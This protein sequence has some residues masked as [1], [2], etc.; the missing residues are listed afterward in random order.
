MI[1]QATELNGTNASVTMPGNTHGRYYL[2]FTSTAIGQQESNIVVYS[3]ERE[4][5]VVA[6]SASD[7]LQNI[8][9][10]SLSGTILKELTGLDTAKVEILLPSGVYIIRV[11]SLENIETKKIACKQ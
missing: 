2:N 7:K 8:K 5:V 6:T 1:N 4:R 9:I 11:Q 10:F 3:P